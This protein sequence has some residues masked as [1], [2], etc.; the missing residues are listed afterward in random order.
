MAWKW[1]NHVYAANRYVAVHVNGVHL[2]EHQVV[3][4]KALGHPLPPKA[5][6]HHVDGNPRNNTPS[7]LVICQDAAYHKLLHRRARI[8]KMGG[9]PNTQAWCGYCKRLRPIEEFGRRSTGRIL[10]VCQPCNQSY[11]AEWHAYNNPGQKNTD[12]F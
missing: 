8:V 2:W 10:N 12:D 7:N 5:H 9:N 3:A 11:M 1:T 6:I 4:E